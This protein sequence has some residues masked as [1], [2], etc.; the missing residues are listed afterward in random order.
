MLKT[1]NLVTRF[2][3]VASRSHGFSR[4]LF[5]RQSS[6]IFH[7]RFSSVYKSV[8][9]IDKIYPGSSSSDFASMLDQKYP[10]SY[11]KEIR[12]AFSGFIPTES[13]KIRSTR[14]SGPGGQAVNTSNTKVEIRFNVEDAEWIPIWIKKKFIELQKHRINKSGDFVITSEKTRT[15]LLNQADCMDKIRHYI[16]EAEIQATPKEPTQEMVEKKENNLQ[17]AN[18]KRLIQKRMHSIKKAG[19]GAL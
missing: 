10:K 12:E 14:S 18:Q 16:R 15:Q 19:R 9:S 11:S 4:V 3:G 13:L 17:K 8:Y 1:M 6:Y 5:S 7:Q 2:F